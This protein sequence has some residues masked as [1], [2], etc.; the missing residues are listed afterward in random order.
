MK[1]KVALLS[2][3]LLAV[4][5]VPAYAQVSG[6]VQD[7][8]SDNGAI[9]RHAFIVQ[10]RTTPAA[11]YTRSRR[12]RTV[13]PARRPSRAPQ[14]PNQ[15]FVWTSGVSVNVDFEGSRIYVGVTV[16]NARDLIAGVGE[17]N[18]VF[19]LAGEDIR[20][21]S[22]PRPALGRFADA[23]V[24]VEVALPEGTVTLSPEAIVSIL[25]QGSGDIRI[26][27]SDVPH[28]LLT[29]RQQNALFATDI[30][31]TVTI[32][33]GIRPL[34]NLIAPVY[35]TV[36]VEFTG[37]GSAFFMDSIGVFTAIPVNTNQ[38]AVTFETDQLSAVVV[39]RDG[40]VPPIRR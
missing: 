33:T 18:V 12:P 34:S 23:G 10:S 26:S 29:D 8:S 3:M 37:N 17:G 31:R 21:A 14:D 32:K 35:V 15:S 39:V 11:F 19:N 7:F 22:F 30:V 16:A 36:P 6:E 25:A 38:Q 28:G 20:E 5:A 27:V 9:S 13:A 4:S 1:R 2:A 40:G 24:S